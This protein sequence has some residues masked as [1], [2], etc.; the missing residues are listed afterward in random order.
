M[1]RNKGT[2]NFAANF[3]VKMQEA[4]D[5]R[6]VVSAKA[7][8]INK[9]TWP[10]DGDTI[11]LYNG[12]IVGVAEEHAA[13]MLIDIAKVTESDYSGWIRID[14]GAAAQVEI[15]DNLESDAADKALSAKQGKVLMG[16]INTI[17]GKLSGV[18]TYKGSKA[19]FAELPAEGNVSGDVWNVEEAYNGHSAG[20]NWAWNGTEWDALA[21]SIDLSNYFNKEEVAAAVKL[22][23]DRAKEEEGRLALLI[24]GNTAAAAAAQSK[25]DAN[26][27]QI[28]SLSQS[29]GEINLLLN[30]EEDVDTDGLVG[31][32]ALV[33][34]KN[35]DQDTRLTNLEKLVS[36]GEAGEGG[37]TLL[38]M[39]NQN[40]ADIKTLQDE[41]D[42]VEGRLDDAEAA[43]EANTSAIE[44]LKGTGEGSV[45][46][47]I[48][49]ALAWED[50]I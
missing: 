7:D 15:V 4:L 46:S 38:E 41:M 40:A 37:A 3:Q 29:I 45:A 11:Y 8:L 16:E 36:G 30:G 28:N 34:S 42:A 43:I 9:E 13:Y 50:V 31:R 44:G 24:E 27:G 49:E 39:V 33:E 21:G 6:V 47:Q 32:L 26:E 23:E 10:Y 35:S 12:L 2:F 19:T 1:A 20:T 17:A 14:A 5:P 18:Y 48:S 22:E 25:A